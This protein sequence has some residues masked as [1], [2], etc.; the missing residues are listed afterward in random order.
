M[1]QAKR[2]IITTDNPYYRYQFSATLPLAMASAPSPAPP[3]SGLWQTAFPRRRGFQRAFFCACGR[4]LET[5]LAR[6]RACAWE[7]PYSARC[8]GGHRAAVLERDAHCCQAC[9]SE[10]LLHVHHRHPGV[11]DPEWL[12]T[13]CAGCHARVHR[14]EALRHRLPPVLLD[15]WEEQHPATPRQLQFAWEALAA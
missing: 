3:A 4:P 6:C 14:L 5:R 2:G 11:H 8:F 15:F 12:V 1:G 7:L 13:L 10:S 9:G